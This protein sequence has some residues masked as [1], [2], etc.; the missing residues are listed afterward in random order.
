MK[1][2]TPPAAT[3]EPDFVAAAEDFKKGGW[4]VSLL[5][6]AGMLARMLLDDESHPLIFWIRRIIA[7]AIVGV[8]AYFALWSADIDGLKKSIIMTTAGA[9][10]PELM[11]WLRKKYKGGLDEKEK[12]TTT[13]RRSRSRK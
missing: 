1:K 9:G 12:K 5:G 10:S 11:E 3:N 7:G 13:R 8:L 2:M 4:I 6:G